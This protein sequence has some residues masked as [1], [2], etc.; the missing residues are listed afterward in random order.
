PGLLAHLE[1]LDGV[2]ELQVVVA[3]ADAALEALADLGGVIL[4]PLQRLDRQVVGHHHAVPDQPRLAVAGDRAGPDHAAGDVAEPWHPE[5][6]ADLRTAEVDLLVLGLEHALEGRL[7]L[8]DRLVDDRVVADV[9]ALAVGQLPRLALRPDVEADHDRVRGGGQVDVVLGDAADAAVHDP[10]RHLVARHLD[11]QQ[12]VLQGLHRPGAVTLDDQVELLDLAFAEH[13]VQVLQADP[14]AALRQLGVA[15]AGLPAA[16]DLPGH[17]VLL[18]DQERVA[19]AGHRG[20]PEHQHRAGRPGLLHR[21]AG[22]V[23]HRPDPAERVAGHDRVADAQRAALHQ[24][25]RHRTATAVQVGLQGGALRRLIRIGPQVERG[26]RGEQDRLQQAL[27]VDPGLR[28]DV[29]E[30]RVA[31]VLLGH[32]PGLGAL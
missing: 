8:V 9:D 16:G 25:G 31:A 10:Q 27:D 19:G 12:R 32:Q 18:D 15:L 29:D 21:L 24:H 23:V 22:F 30:H 17:P 6:L 26:V 1:G 2:L 4:E 14:A 11:L 3:E 13:P 20:E 28:R 5:D 7:D